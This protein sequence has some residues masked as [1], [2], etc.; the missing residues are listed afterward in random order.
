MGGCLTTVETA[1]FSNAR[2]NA[3]IFRL[4]QKSLYIYAML[5]G[6]VVNTFFGSL[7]AKVTRKKARK[8]LN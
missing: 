6:I 3:G 5:K 4:R 2:L 8:N 7:H 1:F